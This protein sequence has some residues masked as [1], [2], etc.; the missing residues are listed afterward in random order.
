MK[1]N[2]YLYAP[3]FVA[4]HG[5]VTTVWLPYAVGCVWSYAMT[6]KRLQDN[7]HLAG[8]GLLRDPVDQVVNSLMW[9]QPIFVKL[10]STIAYSNI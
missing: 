9:L 1:Q 4:G 8:L 7:F 3:N 6:N 2:V 5:S 10:D